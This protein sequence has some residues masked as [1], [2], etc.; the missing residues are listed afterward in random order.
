M[1]KKLEPF[2]PHIL[3][4]TR[5]ILGVQLITH[6]AQKLL[7]AFGGVPAGTPAAIVWIAGSIELVGGALLA[8]G[9]FTRPSAFLNSGLLAAGYFMAHAPQGLW[10]IL[11]GGELAIIYSWLA[12]YLAA[13]GPGSWSLDSLRRP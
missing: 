13:K 2:A 1:S 11:N 12:L 10:P 5:A 8:V 3:G 7:G 4:I 6:G 9:L